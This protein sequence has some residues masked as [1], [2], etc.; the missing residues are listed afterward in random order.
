MK[1][2]LLKFGLVIAA[3]ALTGC[4]TGPRL[5]QADVRTVAAQP[6]GAAVLQGAHYRFE[7]GPAIVGQLPPEKLE[8][9]A[10]AAFTR[11][12]LVRDEAHPRVSV[13]VSGGASAYW[14][15][16]W[17]RRTGWGGSRLSFG[18]GHGWR[19]GALGFG[20][21]LPM[22]DPDIPVYVSEVSLM[23]RDLQTGQIVYDTRARHDGPWHDT[24]NVIAALFAAAL[25]GY[26]S[27]AQMLRRVDVPLLPPAAGAPAPT[28]TAPAAAPAPAPSR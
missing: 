26:P 8:A 21:G 6:P 7:R 10:Q 15:D 16:G 28:V 27:P 12:G 19:S 17:G 23:M 25:E 18:V 1:N 24:D 5:V 13:Q 4:A 9:M 11:V 22:G 14:V 3:A 20:F 2:L